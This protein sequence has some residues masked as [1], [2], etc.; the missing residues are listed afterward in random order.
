MKK[1]IFIF[2]FSVLIIPLNA[3]ADIYEDMNN[4]MRD[5]DKY[6]VVP[7]G[8]D[9]DDSTDRYMCWAAALA[10]TLPF[11]GWGVEDT[12]NEYS[13]EYD[14]YHEFLEAYPDLPGWP[15]E[16][17]ESYLSWH[18]QTS[19]P[20]L[21]NYVNPFTYISNMSTA[22][23]AGQQLVDQIRYN[24]NE[25]YDGDDDFVATI[26]A[27]RP[28]NS[29]GGHGITAWGYSQPDANNDD[30]YTVF[31]T[32]SD[33]ADGAGLVE[34]DL[35]NYGSDTW[36]L[37]G[38][39]YGEHSWRLSNVWTI[40]PKP[41]TV[42]TDSG[43]N[44]IPIGNPIQIMPRPINLTPVNDLELYYLQADE[45]PLGPNSPGQTIPEPSTLIMFSLG[46]LGFFRRKK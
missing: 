20:F 41:G 40:E 8:I 7:E 13:F 19:N 30:Y 33:D 29:Q 1:I 5:V 17:F 18:Y 36:Y 39:Y 14:V 2:I 37:E 34:Y 22:D 32:D 43:P 23:Y 46:L 45:E 31:I 24:M 21:P 15:H 42:M 6:W 12:G 11:T 35:I 3:K 44:L 28:I 16:G 26:L 38:G 4:I 27:I 10:N 9:S 25:V